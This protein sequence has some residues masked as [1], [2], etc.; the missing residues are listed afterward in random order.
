MPICNSW[1][2]NHMLREISAQVAADAHGIV[3]LDGAAWHASQEIELPDNLSLL[4]I[5]PYSPELNPV[6]LIWHYLRSHWLS[7]QIFEDLEA[8]MDACERAWQ[9]FLAEPGLIA[10]LCRTDWAIPVEEGAA[11]NAT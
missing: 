4:P 11:T 8:V 9:R 6:E 2:M 5:P 10:T 3:L 7:S 1:A